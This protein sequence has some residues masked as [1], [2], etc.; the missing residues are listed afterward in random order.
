MTDAEINDLLERIEL[1]MR[2]RASDAHCALL[3]AIGTAPLSKEELERA[4]D[5]LEQHRVEMQDV[6]RGA[7]AEM[8]TM[9]TTG[10]TEVH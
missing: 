8:R 9:L 7:I 6:I 1:R 3:K 10:S 5:G 2:E 4:L